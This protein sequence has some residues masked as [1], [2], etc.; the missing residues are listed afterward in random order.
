M[1]E[2]GEAFV[3]RDHP[4]VGE[5]GVAAGDGRVR[6][7]MPGKITQLSVKVGDRVTLGQPLL[8]LEAMKMEHALNAPFDGVVDE[9]A[10]ELGAQVTEG[11]VLARLTA[12]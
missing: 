3:F 5:G 6:A 12:T 2:A 9:V 1:F 10:A 7:P 4:P 8:T 11:S